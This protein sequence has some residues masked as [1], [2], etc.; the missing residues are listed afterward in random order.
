[1][2]LRGGLHDSRQHSLRILRFRKRGRILDIFENM[3]IR[4]PRDD[5]AVNRKDQPGRGVMLGKII[6]DAR[7]QQV[8]DGYKRQH[9]AASLRS[10]AG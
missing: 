2:E 7:L 5:L 10:R 1:M 3:A 6:A 9:S 4:I 8:Q